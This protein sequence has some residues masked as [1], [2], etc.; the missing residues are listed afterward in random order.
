MTKSSLS[1]RFGLQDRV[2][3]VTGAA[4]GIGLATANRLAEAG[5][6]LLLTDLDGA[7]I[8]SAAQELRARGHR[9]E[10]MTADVASP[11]SADALVERAVGT[12]GR[13]DVLVNNAGI[14]PFASVLEV[15]PELWR[16]VI[17]TNL[18]SAFF[19]AQAAAR[20]MVKQERG[21]IVNVA[22]I[23]ALHPSGGLTHYDTSKGGMVMMTRSLALELG[24]RGI[25]VNTVSPGSIDTPGARAA[26][27][28]APAEVAQSFVQRVPLRRTGQPDD[29]ATT[30]VFL[31]SDAASYV[32]GT[33]LVVDG[34]YL[35]T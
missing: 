4:K 17:E 8:D 14:F 16:R 5:A 22:S 10:T 32:T 15:T 35:L 25:R 31:A 7:G 2:A 29:I 34:G 21:S 27:S 13:L 23:D 1:D 20:Q 6:S 3:L 33:N 9:V 30:I 12:L 18:S 19:L 24:P 26:T 28:G 11:G